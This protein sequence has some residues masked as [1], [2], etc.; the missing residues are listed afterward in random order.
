MMQQQM[1][2]GQYAPDDMEVSQLLSLLTGFMAIATDAAAADD[3][4][5]RL[6]GAGAVAELLRLN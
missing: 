4:A 6:P 2:P 1:Q 3:G 5:R